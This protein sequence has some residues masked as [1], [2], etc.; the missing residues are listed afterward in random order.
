MRIWTRLGVTI[1]ILA[2]FGFFAFKT[3]RSSQ[4]LQTRQ[5]QIAVGLAGAG[6]LLWLIQKVHHKPLEVEGDEAEKY[7]SPFYAT[8]SYWGL[9]LLLCGGLVGGANHM[10]RTLGRTD[11]KDR[12]AS[13]ENV[14]RIPKFA[15]ARARAANANSAPEVKL[16]GIGFNPNPAKSSAIINGQ[17]VLCGESAGGVKVLSMNAGSVTVDVTGQVKVLTLK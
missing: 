10:K 8:G 7:E 3:L 11:W 6:A 17:T 16:Q 12:I 14:I 4:F 15:N 5:K 2:L 9:I 1:G 13:L